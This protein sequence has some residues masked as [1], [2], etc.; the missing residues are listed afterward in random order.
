MARVEGLSEIIQRDRA[1]AEERSI[2]HRMMKDK[3][4]EKETLRR[5]EEESEGR[6]D[7]QLKEG[8]ESVFWLNSGETARDSGEGRAVV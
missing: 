2:M 7:R 8:T 1:E 3:D 6:S 5:K 4:G